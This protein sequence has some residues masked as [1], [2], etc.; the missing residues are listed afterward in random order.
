VDPVTGKG[1]LC[2]FDNLT[3]K[4]ISPRI[5]V[6]YDLFGNGKTAVK[7]SMNKYV[8]GVTANGTGAAANPISRLVN[9]GARTW[10]DGLNGNAKD[11][12]PQCDP[13]N[14]AAN[15]EC[16]PQAG[17][18]IGLGTMNVAAITNTDLLSGW[19]K[20]GYNWEFSAGVQQQVMPRV[21]VDVAYFRRIF[22]NF[23]VTHNQNLTAA[24]FD[25]FSVV[26]PV[27]ARL[28]SVSGQT[29]TG[30]FDVNNASKAIAT[31]NVTLLEQDLPGSPNQI[32][33]WNGVDVN[34]NARLQ[35]G[36]LLQGGISTGRTS[37]NNCDVVALVPDALGNVPLQYCSVTT[38]FLTQAKLIAVYTVPKI[39]VQ[40]SGTFQSLP[41]AELQGTYTLTSA[42]ILQVSTLGR[43]LN[44]SG[45]QK[46]YNLLPGD[47][48][49]LSERVNQLDLRFGKILRYGRTRTNVSVDVF[50]VL[51][52]DTITTYSTVYETLWR[53]TALLQARFVKFSAQFDF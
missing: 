23:T 36:I 46:V 45:G 32:Q 40:V 27:D 14:P 19:N 12:F 21:S 50:N 20:R 51:N 41:G 42:N 10:T 17:T 44:A 6:A 13:L 53:P 29:I 18:G 33:H 37:T 30:L 34:V 5:G 35:N 8:A 49:L 7:A 9:S 16:G 2:G 22:G 31:N 52:S 11:N 47:T 43:T 39:A 3:W 25:Q 15:G 28:G 4:D 26:A 48:P 1:V 24:N 38:P